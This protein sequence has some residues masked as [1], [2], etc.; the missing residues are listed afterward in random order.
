MMTR[1]VA[2]K[3]L[4]A[5]ASALPF[6]ANSNTSQAGRERESPATSA[7]LAQ[8]GLSSRQLAGQR[9]V[10]SYPGLTPPESLLET[11]R[12]GE[13][14]G[15][16]FFG[17]NIESHDQIAAVVDR[18]RATQE[19]SP[20]APPLLLMTDQE[21]GLVRR[22]P[23]APE[24]SAKQIGLAGDPGSA[25][26]QAGTE[27]G[28]NL[29]SAGMNV[30]LAPVLGVYRQPGDFLDQFERSFSDDPAT[31]GTCAGAFI[32]A[33]QQA[34]VAATAKHFP[35]LGTASASQN[36]D[37]APVTLQVS[38]SVLRE[39]DEVPYLSA[40]D[41]N[42]KLI[43]A[44]WALYPDLDAENPAGLSA[45]VIRGELRDR[46]GYHGVTITD[47]LEAG[48][49]EA[50]GD[51]AQRGVLAAQAG[52]DLILCSARDVAQGSSVTT[53]LA[54][55]FDTGELDPADFA[56]A[57]ERVDALRSG[58][59]TNRF[60]P[61][62]GFEAGG[63]FLSYW[64]RFGGLPVFGYPITNEYTDPGTGLVTQYFERARFEWH[65]GL[66]PD[67]YDV[68][69]GL[70]GVELAT[71]DGLLDSAP[72]QPVEGQSD[73]N[74]TFF[75]E[76]GHRLC[77]GFRDH[78]NAHGGLAI[79]GYPISEEFPDPDTGLTVQYF[80]R[81]RLEWHPENAPEWQV[82][83]GLLGRQLLPPGVQSSAG[84]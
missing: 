75:P 69:L 71:R 77:F 64:V 53:A 84:A 76:T 45:T 59:T 1:R 61:E 80:E 74:C 13:A 4:A 43:M 3:V 65:P 32:R 26:S 73:A 20:V 29:A 51:N 12:A 50:F 46:L 66:Q 42:V 8:T 25:A 70:L 17:E 47:A 24:Q 22:L 82:L 9:V 10:Y 34:G 7:R 19:Q 48:A 78:W 58:L 21:G 36:T 30:N 18:L 31:V 15:V 11:I 33:Q 28:Q 83:G 35:G 63:A 57:I 56:A 52:M 41:A 39:V 23:G 54:N 67:R 27:A 37:A 81:Q 2:L 40:L 6:V 16:I 49:L 38:T 62:T 55:A 79:L 68:E 60:F 72:F 5:S 14:A 44:S